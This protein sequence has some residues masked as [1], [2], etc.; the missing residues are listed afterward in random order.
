V[1]VRDVAATSVGTT[2]ALALASMPAHAGG[3]SV[4]VLAQAQAAWTDNLFSVPEERDPGSTLPPH[5]ADLYYQLR[6]GVLV[7]YETPRTVHHLSYDIEAN[8]YTEHTEAWS[9]QHIAG[10]R[11]FFLTSPK[12]EMGASAQFS[13][14]ELNALSTRTAA[15]DGT[16]P[17]IP[18]GG[19]SFVAIDL[20]Q[21]L[22]YAATRDVRLTQGLRAR[23]FT[24]TDALETES[25]GIEIGG[26][27]GADRA[28][29]YSA[30]SIQVSSS[31]VTLERVAA[32]APIESNDQVNVG[33]IV[34]WRRDFGPRWSALLDA[35]VTSIIPLD[36]GDQLVIQPTIGGQVGYFPNWGSA[37]LAIRRAVAPNLY[38]AQNTITDSAVANAWLPLPWLTD[39]PHRPKLSVQGTFGASRTRL[40]DTSTGDIESGFDVY[41]GDVAVNYVPR[42]GVTVALRLQH[43]RQVADESA[44]MEVLGYVRNTIMLSVAG[45]FPDRLAAEVPTRASLRVDR[46]NVTPVGEE[47]AP[48]QAPGAP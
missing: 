7:T 13:T 1:R 3:Y 4:H 47:V 25:D 29:Q 33:S 15:S 10:W 22:N 44:D 39:D 43:L 28:W 11:G 5:E 31:F 2:V 9:L 35:G 32:M 18:A 34:S 16:V 14:G 38:L 20:G 36:E 45:R 41:A 40:I 48:A 19:S 6:P 23:R 8:L 17:V 12:S 24:T 37:G 26:N 21:N 27:L 46:S 30:A 42:D